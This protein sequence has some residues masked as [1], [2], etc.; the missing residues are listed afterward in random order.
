MEKRKKKRGT[1]AALLFFYQLLTASMQQQDR[2]RRWTYWLNASAIRLPASAVSAWRRAC[3]SR[4][5]TENFLPQRRGSASLLRL[6]TA[7]GC[8]ARHAAICFAFRSIV[9]ESVHFFLL[10]VLFLFLIAITFFRCR[11]RAPGKKSPIGKQAQLGHRR[12]P[13]ISV[14]CSREF[15]AA[16]VAAAQNQLLGTRGAGDVSEILPPPQ[17]THSPRQTG[18]LNAEPRQLPPWLK[19]E[20]TT[21]YSQRV[22]SSHYS[23]G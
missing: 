18:K 9:T 1:V 15:L 12:R 3:D 5:V 11:Q 2:Q 13:R 19:T 21:E 16:A 7:T 6:L 17:R 4:I 22:L 10:L 20:D 14:C 23:K 8:P